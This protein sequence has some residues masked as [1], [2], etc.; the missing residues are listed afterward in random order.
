[1]RFAVF[2]SVPWFLVVVINVFLIDQANMT[3]LGGGPSLYVGKISKTSEG[4]LQFFWGGGLYFG[5][6]KGGVGGNLVVE[7]AGVL[8]GE[9]HSAQHHREVHRLL[10]EVDG[11]RTLR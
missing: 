1:M 5:V 11:Q 9:D 3:V 6:Y 2:L 10:V 8:G 7:L 4:G